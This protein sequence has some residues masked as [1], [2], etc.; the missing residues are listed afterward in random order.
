LFKVFQIHGIFHLESAPSGI[1]EHSE[2]CTLGCDA[3]QSG[4]SLPIFWENLV[5]L[6]LCNFC[7]EDGA[8]SY[9]M[10]VTIET[11]RCHIPQGSQYFLLWQPHTSSSDLKKKRKNLNFLNYNRNL[12]TL[13]QISWSETF[14]RTL[15]P[16]SHLPDD[17]SSFA[18]IKDEAKSGLFHEALPSH[19]W[20]EQRKPQPPNRDSARFGNL[21]LKLN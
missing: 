16:G 20:W 3:V 2:C 21:T 7:P 1:A 4:R 5:H 6:P 12:K 8:A 18:E 15:G 9:E 19:F 17:K 11:S 14:N 10:S 13:S